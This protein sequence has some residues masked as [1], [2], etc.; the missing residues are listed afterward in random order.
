MT[1]AAESPFLREG[2]GSGGPNFVMQNSCE[3]E[4]QLNTFRYC[5]VHALIEK[6]NSPIRNIFVTA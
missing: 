1:A 4:D 2:Y 6:V 3:L 5:Q